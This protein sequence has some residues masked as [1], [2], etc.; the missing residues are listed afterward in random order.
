VNLLT[1]NQHMI[2]YLVPQQDHKKPSICEQQ[3]TN[4]TNVN[5]L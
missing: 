2:G 1:A 4:E 3:I 5:A